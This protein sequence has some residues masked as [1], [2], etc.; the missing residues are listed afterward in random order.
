MALTKRYLTA[1][2][3]FTLASCNYLSLNLN[4]DSEVVKNAKLNGASDVSIYYL[5]YIENVIIALVSGQRSIYKPENEQLKFNFNSYFDE[6]KIRIAKVKTVN[7]ANSYV[8]K[9]ITHYIDYLTN[10]MIELKADERYHNNSISGSAS[11]FKFPPIDPADFVFPQS[12]EVEKPDDS[13]SSSKSDKIIDNDGEEKEDEEID[14]MALC[15]NGAS[16]IKSK[17]FAYTNDLQKFK[18]LLAKAE[19]ENDFYNVNYYAG[20]IGRVKNDLEALIKKC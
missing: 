9:S 4:E 15:K 3:L 8:K 7:F 11:S 6:A 5:K 2:F 16:T 14:Y 13:A 18:K 17:V 19:S 12:Q 10:L 1:L 20:R